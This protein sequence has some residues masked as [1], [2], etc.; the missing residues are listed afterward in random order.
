MQTIKYKN[1]RVIVSNCVGYSVS[2]KPEDAPMR[3]ALFFN[4]VGGYKELVAFDT[5]DKAQIMMDIIDNSG[6]D[7]IGDKLYTIV[8]KKTKKVVMED[9]ETS[10][11]R[12]YDKEGNRIPY[13]RN[14]DWYYFMCENVLDIE[15]IIKAFGWENNVVTVPR[16]KPNVAYRR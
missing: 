16:E 5:E 11:G 15:E 7:Y 3:F 6:F 1:N 8:D 12:K 9:C 4:H 2:G 10:L 14:D 13:P